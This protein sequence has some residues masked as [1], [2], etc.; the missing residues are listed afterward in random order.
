[1]R[2]RLRVV[3]RFGDG[4]VVHRFAR[5]DHTELRRSAANVVLVLKYGKLA[6]LCEDHSLLLFDLTDESIEMDT[7]VAITAMAST[8][9]IATYTQSIIRS[10]E[11]IPRR[12]GRTLSL[13]L[14]AA[15]DAGSVS[16]R[17]VA[18]ERVLSVGST[19]SRE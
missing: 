12:A 1:M 9:A 7:P 3:H 4:R 13:V 16:V 8:S 17:S 2:I 11:V 15:T 5:L 14:S 19:S 6:F 18:Y 10:R